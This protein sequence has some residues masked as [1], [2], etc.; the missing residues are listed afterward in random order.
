MTLYP[1]HSSV[2]YI[3]A[4]YKGVSKPFPE[5]KYAFKFFYVPEK[6]TVMGTK[7]YPRKKI[8]APHLKGWISSLQTW[9]MTLHP[10]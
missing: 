3:T 4:S 9:T 7:S 10:S 1:L 5:V 8:E 2:E 6:I